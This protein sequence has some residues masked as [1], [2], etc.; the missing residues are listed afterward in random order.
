M[1]RMLKRYGRKMRAKLGIGG[2][3]E[4]RI[5]SRD[6]RRERLACEE[7]DEE[8]RVLGDDALRIGDSYSGT[9]ETV[10][11]LGSS[12]RVI[13]QLLLDS[14]PLLRGRSQTLLACEKV[15]S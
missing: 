9:L 5:R 8:H 3:E 7:E 10:L 2:W 15:G 14:T 11:K 13:N 4:I 12:T 6:A 1:S